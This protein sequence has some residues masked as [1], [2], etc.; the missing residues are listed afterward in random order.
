MIV[1]SQ[2]EPML[3]I[4]NLLLA[5][6]FSLSINNVKGQNAISIGLDVSSSPSNRSTSL[7]IGGSVEYNKSISE[8]LG[9]R[10]YCGYNY[11]KSNS[12]D[13]HISFLPI[14][15]GIEYFL[16][17]LLFLYVESGVANYNSDAANNWYFSYAFGT[18]YTVPFGLKN[19]FAKI[20]LFF[21]SVRIAK[22]SSTNW[23]TLRFAYG[24]NFGKKSL[25]NK[26]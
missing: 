23:F 1:L 9:G 26:S 25:K 22:I 15:V 13:S 12:T 6:I 10:L 7:G 16:N 5:V 19:N 8:K 24:L 11:F 3:R 14:R 18:G 21:N 4:N 2:T 17:K 20:S